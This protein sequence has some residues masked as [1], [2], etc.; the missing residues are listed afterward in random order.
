MNSD[1]KRFYTSTRFKGRFA[2]ILIVNGSLPFRVYEGS[3]NV[4]NFGTLKGAE[5]YLKSK[6]FIYMGEAEV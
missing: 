4:K 5:R 1:V 2:H 3:W 6:G